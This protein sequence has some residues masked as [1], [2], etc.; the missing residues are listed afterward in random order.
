M[1]L[2]LAVPDL[3]SCSDF[4]L[5]AASGAALQLWCTGFSLQRFSHGGAQTP[6]HSGF[7]DPWAQWLRLP[8]SRVQVQ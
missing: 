2:F 7:V 3:C 5:A 4:S 8:D 6:G 1:Y